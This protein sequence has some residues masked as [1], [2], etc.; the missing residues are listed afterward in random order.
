ASTASRDAFPGKPYAAERRQAERGTDRDLEIDEHHE[1]AREAEHPESGQ[2]KVD[3]KPRSGW[4]EGEEVGRHCNESDDRV[5]DA[6]RR[7]A[8]QREHEDGNR[9][10]EWREVPGAGDDGRCQD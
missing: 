8:D 6:A 3:R 5:E 2:K 9:E 4:P 1:A 10:V 7:E